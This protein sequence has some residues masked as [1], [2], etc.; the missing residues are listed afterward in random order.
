MFVMLDQSGSMVLFGNRW[1]PIVDAIKAFVAAPDMAGVGVGLGYFGLFPPGMPPLDP[2]A[3]GSCNPGDYARPDV[4]IDVLP[5]VR[6]AIENSLNLHSTPGG[7]T[8]TLPALQGSMQ[9]A[10]QWAVAHPDRKV[11]IVL[12]TDGE[13]QGCTGNDVNSVSQVAAAAATT[14]PQINTYVVGVG[15]SLQALNQIAQA[16]GSNMAYLVESGN[17]QQFLDALHSIRRKATSCD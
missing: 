10:T 12:A 16:G 14:N 11:I 5:N 17:T 1:Q 7:G 13:P 2:T 3:P 15:P 9:Y 8:P 4:P 6:M